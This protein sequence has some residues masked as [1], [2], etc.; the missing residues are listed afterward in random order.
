MMRDVSSSRKQGCGGGDFAKL[1]CIVNEI[2]VAP[3]TADDVKITFLGV[4]SCEPC[5]RLLIV[6]GRIV[7]Y[8]DATS[9]SSGDDVVVVHF[10]REMM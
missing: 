9:S 3:T 6:V 1:S 8:S 5:I 2:I 10:K 4:Y 7:W